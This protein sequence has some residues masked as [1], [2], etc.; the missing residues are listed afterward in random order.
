MWGWLLFGFA[1]FVGVFVVVGEVR[2]WLR[3]EDADYELRADF[4]R[5]KA[6]I[7]RREFYRSQGAS[8][9]PHVNKN[10]TI[11]TPAIRSGRNSAHS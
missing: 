7:Q 1:G 6:N 2:K 9:Y 11:C 8:W 3:R 10:G 5:E 4:A